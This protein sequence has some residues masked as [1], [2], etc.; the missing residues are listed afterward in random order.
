[1]K[2]DLAKVLH[3]VLG[4]PM[5]GHAAAACRAAGMAVRL[6]V[7]HQ[8]DAVRA[9]MAD[10]GV[11]FTR[12]PDP[13]GTGDAVRA[14][15]ADLPATGT[16]VVLP[17]DAPLLRADTLRRLLAE[18][19]GQLVT[20]L[21]AVLDDAARYGRI[22]RDGDRVS[23][24]EAAELSDAQLAS[25]R[26]IN[27]GVYAFDL[28]FLH[29]VVP[30]L[31]PHPPKGEIYLTDVL[32]LA[33]ELGRA[34][35]IVHDGDVDEVM[36]VNDRLALSLAARAMAWRV[37][38]AHAEAGVSFEDIDSTVVEVGVQ[39][40]RDVTVGAGCVLRRGAVVGEGVRIGPH[41]LLDAGVLLHPGVVVR[42][43][44]H[45]DRCE[46]LPG[47]VVGPY[48]RLRPG[49]RVGEDCHVGNFCEVKNAVLE[50]GA[51]VNHLSYIGDARVGARTN[52]GAGTITCN[53]DGHGKHHTDIGADAF[54]GSN[55]AL[56]APVSVGDGAIVGAGSTIV[57]DVPADA[58]ALGRGS[59]VV[60]PGLAPRIHARNAERKRQATRGDGASS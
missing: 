12:Q 59:Q 55:T 2:S 36:G 40:G 8:E 54:I 30:G 16:V 56:V 48:A 41:C 19:D 22:V 21:S 25:L 15:L 38:A 46:V 39:L 7:H 27:T 26:E 51:K 3:P 11:T 32:G 10:A 35:V 37:K 52:I 13:R 28:A 60:K 18:H 53:Y 33:S 17:G 29:R 43:F 45:L 44:S 58:L 23:I 14:A 47:A 9:A 24:V 31:L 6:V 4:L 42:A 49:A 50:P 5:V 57:G 20:C 34:R 1:M